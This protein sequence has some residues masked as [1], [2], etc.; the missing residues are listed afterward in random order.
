ME[1]LNLKVWNDINNH[2]L[3]KFMKNDWKWLKLTEG[4]LKWLKMTTL[5]DKK[6]HKKK[7]SE[8]NE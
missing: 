4:V 6:W 1:I 2:N 7:Q 8:K 5:S 3:L